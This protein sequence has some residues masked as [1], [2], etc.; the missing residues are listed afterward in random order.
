MAGRRELAQI[1][2]P[3]GITTEVPRASGGLVLQSQIN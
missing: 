3:E 2:E 1:P